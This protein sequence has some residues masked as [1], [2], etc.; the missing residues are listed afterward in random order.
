M[1]GMFLPGW[2]MHLADM[3]EAQGDLIREVGEI[4]L[5]NPEQLFDLRVE[6]LGKLE[7]GNGRWHEDAVL[8]RVD[9]LAADPDAR[10]QIGLGP[11]ASSRSAF[12]ERVREPFNQ[13]DAPAVRESRS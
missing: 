10:R 12:L 7:S 9:G 4:S 11:A 6:R 13:A 3:S 5:D 1:L 8:D 2:G